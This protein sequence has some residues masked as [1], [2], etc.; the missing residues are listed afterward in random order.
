M[1]L[2]S[3]VCTFSGLAHMDEISDQAPFHAL[4]H[5]SALRSACALISKHLRLYIQPLGPSKTLSKHPQAPIN[6][7]R[8]VLLVSFDDP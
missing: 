5:S 7:T 8:N 1:T 2:Q 6:S 3:K 4:E